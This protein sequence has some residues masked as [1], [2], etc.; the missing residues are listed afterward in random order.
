MQISSRDEITHNNNNNNNNK[1]IY[2]YIYKDISVLLYWNGILQAA[3]ND[4]MK[5]VCN[6]YLQNKMYYLR[7]IP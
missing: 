6:D 5:P 3:I 4:T 1:D 7:F 2:I